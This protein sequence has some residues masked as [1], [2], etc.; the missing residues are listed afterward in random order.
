MNRHIPPILGADIEL[1]NAWIGAPWGSNLEAASLLL[2]QVG[3][4]RKACGCTPGGEAAS[5]G[6]LEWG[7]RWLTNGGC[8]YVNMAHLELCTPETHSA[9]D[10]AAAVHAMIQLARSCRRRAVASLSE[11]QDL[12]VSV[13]NSDGTLGTSWGAHQN[14]TVSRRLWDD[15]FQQR[16]PHLMAL[17]AS[18]MAAAV[19]V[20]G[21]GMVVPLKRG[22]HYATSAR[23]TTWAAW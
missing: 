12:F 21:Q 9:R 16:K 7:R 11:G 19:P 17:L 13:H 3:S 6:R 4:R 1:S 5:S 15:L 22:C 8:V 20:F 18:F 2:R 14:V 23:A 10:H